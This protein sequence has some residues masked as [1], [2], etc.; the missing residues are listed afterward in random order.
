MAYV[1]NDGLSAFEMHILIMW[2]LFPTKIKVKMSFTCFL[3]CL[4]KG[5]EKISI[6]GW[7][8]I[9]EEKQL[10][11]SESAVQINITLRL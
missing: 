1:E 10:K 3:K 9:G 2:T 4:K 8:S 7:L 11:C 6:E 5:C